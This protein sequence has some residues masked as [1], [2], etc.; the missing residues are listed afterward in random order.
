MYFS[1]NPLVVIIVIML[2]VIIRSIITKIT[3]ILVIIRAGE[4]CPTELALVVVS[5]EC[6]K[7]SL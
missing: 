1:K 4:M 3:I 5:R 2:V 7:G 6:R